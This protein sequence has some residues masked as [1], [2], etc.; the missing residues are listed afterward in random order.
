M[1]Q[2]DMSEPDMEQPDMEPSDK[3]FDDKEPFDAGVEANEET[4]PKKF[5]EQLSGKIGQSLRKFT[6]TQGQPDFELEKFA[7]NSLLSATHT[8]E[9]DD[10]DKNDIIKKVNTAGNNDSKEPDMGDNNN[11]NDN[12][13]D[14]EGGSNDNNDLSFDSNNEEGLEEYKVYESDDLFL[15]K[16]KKNNMFQPNSNDIL[17][18]TEPTIKETIKNLFNSKKIVCLTENINVKITRNF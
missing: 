9:M 16:P 7:I 4:D 6:E 2:P 12:G 17:D 14:N 5:I 13:N 1:G 18:S 15:D 8:S 11:N 10:N 3:P